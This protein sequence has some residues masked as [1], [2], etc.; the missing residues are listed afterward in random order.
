MMKMKRMQI[1][2]LG[3]AEVRW[4]Q[5]GM[6]DKRKYVMIFSGGEKNQHGVGIMI[7]KKVSKALQGYLPISD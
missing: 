5:S 1:D 4:T 3:L 2:V 6:T 7:T